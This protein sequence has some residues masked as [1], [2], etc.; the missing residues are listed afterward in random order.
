MPL[1]KTWRTFRRWTQS[2]H[3]PLGHGAPLAASALFAAAGLSRSPFLRIVAYGL[4]TV[5]AFLIA[6]DLARS[7]LER[8]SMAPIRPQLDK[9]AAVHILLTLF[10]AAVY[11]CLIFAGLGPWTPVSFVPPVFLLSGLVAWRNVRLWW[12]EACDYEQELKEAEQM[13]K[14]ATRHDHSAGGTQR[15]DPAATACAGTQ[16]DLE[17]P[18][19]LADRRTSAS[20]S[21]PQVWIVPRVRRWR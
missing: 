10:L 7:L 20:Y 12:R 6:I 21:A 15:I 8:N 17:V 11:T 1:G 14:A 18:L 4:A 13:E 16:S 9:I 3:A 2:V 5:L 19:D